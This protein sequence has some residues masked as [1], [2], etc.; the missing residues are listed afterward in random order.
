MYFELANKEK[1]QSLY[2]ALNLAA[3]SF[4][5]MPKSS[6]LFMDTGMRRCDGVKGCTG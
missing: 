5:H 2:V 4:R 6:G 1:K 3:I